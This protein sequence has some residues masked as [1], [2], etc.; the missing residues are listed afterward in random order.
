[1]EKQCSLCHN[2]IEEDKEYYTCSCNPPHYMYK[3]CMK[4]CEIEECPFAQSSFGGP[5]IET[6]KTTPTGLVFHENSCFLDVLLQIFL[7]SDSNYLKDV[8][9]HQDPLSFDYNENHVGLCEKASIYGHYTKPQ[10][11]KIFRSMAINLQNDFKRLVAASEKQDQSCT[12]IRENLAVCAR[13]VFGSSSF[14]KFFNKTFVRD[15]ILRP[16][17]TTFRFTRDIEKDAEEVS[18]IISIY[19]SQLRIANAAQTREILHRH[20]FFAW[21][22]SNTNAMDMIVT[23][24]LKESVTDS[25][26]PGTMND[27]AEIYTLFCSIFPPLLMSYSM[28]YNKDKVEVSPMLDLFS[29]VDTQS[30]VVVSLQRLA[31]NPLIVFNN[32]YQYPILSDIHFAKPSGGI[33]LNVTRPL[34]EHIL[35]AGERFTLVAIIILNGERGEA[36]GAYAG[37]MYETG[38]SHYTAYI[39]YKS[40]W[41]YY[42]DLEK[43]APRFKKI[44]ALAKTVFDANATQ[45]PYMFFYS[46]SDFT[47]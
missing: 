7:S 34:T 10:L 9:L 37:I 1:M 26:A 3:S 13:S 11:I 28:Y 8:L 6:F 15:R 16:V 29:Y 22:P 20:P 32:M 33:S 23:N 27:P 19:V 5:M 30:D 36:G 17:Y 24:I 4:A 39:R 41:Y 46:R 42:N 44:G 45:I 43:K 31:A 2:Q 38:A 14:S 18:K 40:Y 47:R 25:M 35:L 12:L 21:I